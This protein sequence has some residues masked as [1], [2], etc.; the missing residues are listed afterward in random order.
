MSH[1]LS[2][3]TALGS[4]QGYAAEA[5]LALLQWKCEY[6]VAYAFTF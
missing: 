1:G 2:V 5:A 3:T 6:P 4:A